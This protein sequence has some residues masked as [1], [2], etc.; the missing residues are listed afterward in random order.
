MSDMPLIHLRSHLRSHR[1]RAQLG[2]GAIA[3]IVVVVM[4]SA[5]AAGIA[6]LG[7]TSSVNSG[8]DVGAANARMAARAGVE[9]GLYKVLRGSWSGCTSSSQTL[10]L[11]SSTGMWVTVRCTSPTAAYIEGGDSSGAARSVRIYAIEAVACNGVSSC[12]D[13]SRVGQP[14]YVERKR[15]AQATTP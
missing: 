15:A 12:P 14:G 3:A 9:W 2:F 11:R 10:D 7:F 13:D 4:L 6:R 1:R 5:L 8:Q